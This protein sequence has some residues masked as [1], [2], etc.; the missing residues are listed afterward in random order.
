MRITVTTY[1]GGKSVYEHIRGLSVGR[2][3][4]T[5]SDGDNQLVLL[6]F[7]LSEPIRLTVDEWAHF[8]AEKE[9]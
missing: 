8:K 7:N 1:D 4:P 3:C 6:P 5:C 2:D 9:F